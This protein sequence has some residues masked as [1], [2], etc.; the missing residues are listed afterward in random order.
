[1]R[2]KKAVYN[3]FSSLL[4]EV[5]AIFAAFILPRLILSH[6]GSGHNGVTSAINQFISYISLLTAGVGSVTRASLYKPLEEKNTYAISGIINATQSFMRKIAFIFVGFLLAVALLYPFLVQNDFSWFFTFSLALILGLST[7]AQYFFGNTY[8]MLLGADQKDYIAVIIQIITLVVKTAFASVLILLGFSLHIVM[9]A[10]SIS[11]MLNPILINLYVKKH[12]KIDTKVP[13][14]HTAIKQRW[15]AFAHQIAN[16]VNNNTD[17][18]VLSFFVPVKEISVYTVYALVATGIRKFITSFTKGITAAF[19]NMIAKNETKAI[20]KNT[21]QFEFLIHSLSVVVF[22]SMALLITP[23]VLI[24]THKIKDV[25]YNQVVFGLLLTTA[26]FF[27]AIRIVYSAITAAAG[28]FRQTRTAAIL[29]VV[30]NIVVSL[31]FVK[32]LGLVGVLIGTISAM[33]YRAFVYSFYV[34]KHIIFRSYWV[35]IKRLLV[36]AL[37]IASIFLLVYLLKLPNITN[38]L[39]WVVQAIIITMTGII[40]TLVFSLIFYKED[41]MNFLQFIKNLWKRR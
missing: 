21:L 4:F 36:S 33:V 7:F 20:L 38:I 28:H 32:K 23:F 31:I 29:E 11:L 15:D 22:T 2:S 39:E 12:Y 40:L 17:L 6:F 1:M 8:K 37:N 3:T 41:F 24:Y 19:G 16:F 13:A 35:F 9:L 10:S 27:F 34:S 18:V 14:D 5:V 25:N 26:E 30:I